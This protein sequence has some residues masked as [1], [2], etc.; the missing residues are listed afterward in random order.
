VRSARANSRIGGSERAL[1]RR[2][3]RRRINSRWCGRARE[4]KY[5][6]ILANLDKTKVN[7]FGQVAFVNQEVPLGGN[8]LQCPPKGDRIAPELG[9]RVI[10]R[11]QFFRSPNEALTLRGEVRRT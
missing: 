8:I 6:Y 10:F 11:A 1:C 9:E 3:A 4:R 5:G 7:E 2:A